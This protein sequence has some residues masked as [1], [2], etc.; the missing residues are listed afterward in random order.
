MDSFTVRAR[1][2]VVRALAAGCLAGVLLATARAQS[3][4]TLQNAAGP[5][6]PSLQVGMLLQGT[7]P[8]VAEHRYRIAGKIRPLLLFW[9]GRDN[10]GG[11]RVRWRRG[12]GGERGYD[13]LIG[14]DPAR[15]P[16]KTNRWGFIMEES[17]AGGA[18][19]LGVMKKSDEETLEQAKSNVAAE[20]AGGVTFNMIRATVDPS[21]SVSRVTS[22]TVGRDYSYHELNPLMELLVKEGAPSAIRRVPVPPGGRLGLLLSL[23]E[24]L[25]DG[26]ET[27]RSTSKA[28]GRK[29][30]P[31]AY[32]RKQYDLLRVSSEIEKQ[33]TYGGTT[34]PRL[35]KSAFEIKPR[36]ESWAETFTI[37]CGVDGPLA[38]VPVFM[39]Y[40]PR[41]WFKLELVLDER[42]AF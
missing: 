23:T 38:E 18:T 15:A 29:S 21:E 20:A 25:H 16:R 32:Y 40:Q 30:L 14:S 11:A 17:N 27:V 4:P 28:P 26:V 33:V 19:I 1:G 5:A 22:A 8:V 36:G 9:I 2:P 12:E 24:L 6:S 7:L 35:L 3:G 39:T 41:W 34:Y 13:L 10:V 31:Y 37:V 42:Q